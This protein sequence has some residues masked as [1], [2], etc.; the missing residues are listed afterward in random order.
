MNDNYQ[1]ITGFVRISFSLQNTTDEVDRLYIALKEI[2]VKKEYYKRMY[3]Q[4]KNGEFYRQD[5]KSIDG[6][7]IFEK[8][9]SM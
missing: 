5:G 6:K 1:S 3:I 2:S 4:H 7:E 8:Y 9:L